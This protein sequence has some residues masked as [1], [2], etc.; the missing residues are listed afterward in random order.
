MCQL[1]LCCR[2]TMTKSKLK[3]AR[4]YF[5]LQVCL[6]VESIMAEDADSQN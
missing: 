1:F 2:D 3:I 4:V 6:E 5:D